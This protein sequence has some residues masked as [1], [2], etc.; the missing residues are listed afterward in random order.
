[1]GQKLKDWKNN[2]DPLKLAFKVNKEN[3]K[4]IGMQCE[5]SLRSN[6]GIDVSKKSSNETLQEIR[7]KK[8]RYCLFWCFSIWAVSVEWQTW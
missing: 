4:M 7:H 2:K 3:Y 1:M 6:A 8:K 5:C